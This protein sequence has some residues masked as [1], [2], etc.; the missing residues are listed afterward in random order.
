MTETWEC[1]GCGQQTSETH[2]RTQPDGTMAHD[3]GGPSA[4]PRRWMNAEEG[5]EAGRQIAE[6]FAQVM[7]D[8]PMPDPR[9]FI[10]SA[11]RFAQDF[12]GAWRQDL[13]HQLQEFTDTTA[14]YE[15]GEDV[16]PGDCWRACLASLLEVPLAEVPHFI[17]LYPLEQEDPEGGHPEGPRWWRESVAWA[18]QQRPGWTLAAWDRPEPWTPFYGFEPGR[19]DLLRRELPEAPERVILTAPSPRG[20][21]NHSVLVDAQT[22][23][24]EHDPFPGGGGVL[25]GPGDRVALVRPEWLEQ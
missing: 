9:P 14:A 15:A 11:P 21:W 16:V 3:P 25:A 5:R 12:L 8:G 7:V 19:V 13:R 22:G 23:E 18:E 17:H 4:E 20:A 6:G 1:G 10:A 2:Y 24:L